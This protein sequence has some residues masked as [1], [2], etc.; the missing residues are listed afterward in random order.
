VSEETFEVSE[1]IQ[2]HPRD[3]R[4]KAPTQI[5]FEAK[6]GDGLLKGY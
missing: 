4:G 6:G 5:E 2:P 1:F 3:E